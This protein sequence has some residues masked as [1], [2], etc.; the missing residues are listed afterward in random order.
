MLDDH[1][2][3]ARFEGMV[4]AARVVFGLSH[5]LE[6]PQVPAVDCALEDRSPARQVLVCDYV[7]GEE[8]DA[9]CERACRAEILLGQLGD[10]Y[11]GQGGLLRCRRRRRDAPRRGARRSGHLQGASSL[12]GPKPPRPEDCLPPGRQRVHVGGSRKV[13]RDGVDHARVAEHVLPQLRGA[14]PVANHSLGDN[15]QLIVSK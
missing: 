10:L 3:L 2:P 1:A 11:L 13:R 14:R 9:K 7:P 5:A 6:C 4:E 12:G 15:S 8:G